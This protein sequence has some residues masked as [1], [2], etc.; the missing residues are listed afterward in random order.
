[1][2]QFLNNHFPIRQKGWAIHFK[3]ESDSPQSSFRCRGYRSN[4]WQLDKLLLVG[5]AGR[6]QGQ[7]FRSILGQRKAFF[8]RRNCLHKQDQTDVAVNL[9]G[10]IGSHRRPLNRQNR[11]QPLV[12]NTNLYPERLL[13]VSGAPG[14]GARILWSGVFPELS[15]AE[16]QY[17]TII[18]PSK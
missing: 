9:A 7:Q 10:P 6:T 18:L 13:S 15:S 2:G 17:G 14:L 16:A 8:K 5:P 12:C 4:I 11:G 1:M 3:K